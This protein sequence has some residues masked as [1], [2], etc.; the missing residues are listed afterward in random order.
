MPIWMHK[1]CFRKAFKSTPFWL[2]K[3]SKNLFLIFIET[4]YNGFDQI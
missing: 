2:K 4:G 3:L 1:K